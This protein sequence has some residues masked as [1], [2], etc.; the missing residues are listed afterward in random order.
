[1]PNAEIIAIGTELLLGEITDTNTAE[2]ARKI[3]S[4]G[5]DLFKTITIGDNAERIA[6]QI[7]SSL[8]HADIIITTGGLGPTVDDPTREAVAKAFNCSLEFHDELWIDI[9]ERFKAYGRSPSENNRRQAFLPQ[10]AVAIR[11]PV[12]TAP[13]FYLK[14]NNKIFFSLPGV[15][16]EMTTLLDNFVIPFIIDTYDL[17]GIILTRT[18]HT[19]G[20]GESIIDEMIDELEK[21][22]NPTVGLAAH[23]G[24]VD[25]RITAKGMDEYD[26]KKLIEP[27]EENIKQLLG[28][29][30]YGFDQDTLHQVIIDSL[31]EKNA[32]IEL[33][34]DEDLRSSITNFAHVI[35]I[36]EIF[37]INKLMHNHNSFQQ[38]VYNDGNQ[39][40]LSIIMKVRRDQEAIDFF[41]EKENK[42][43]EKTVRFGGHPSLFDEWLENQIMNELRLVMR[44]EKGAK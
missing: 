25:I 41:I 1:M 33:W 39:D 10:G 28:N 23:P 31:T 11:N 15:P 19:V 27:V 20:I 22:S 29:Y 26:A 18:I 24:Q 3:N 37:F 7:R 8:S 35:K 43:Y 6:E 9:Q 21:K 32:R 17:K 36:A 44:D 40:C 34:F 30:I 5:V 42:K 14:I 38:S 12:G 4:I 2:I 16:M 13:A